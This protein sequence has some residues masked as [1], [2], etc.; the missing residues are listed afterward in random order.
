MTETTTP[1]AKTPTLCACGTWVAIVTTETD[2]NE[3]PDYNIV[4]ST[5][6]DETTV[7]TFRPGHDA[8]LKSLLI[9][10]GAQSLELTDRG[11]LFTDALGVA[12]RYGFLAQVEAG[13]KRAGYKAD[14]KAQ[15]EVG[16][17]A[18]REARATELGNRAQAKAAKA[19]AN[20]TRREVAT[21]PAAQDAA[22]VKIK[23]GRWEYDAEIDAA[24]NASY[25]DSHGE[26]Q[27]REAGSFRIL[28]P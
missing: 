23:V 8:K 5:N 2:E 15:R 12:R 24:G 27:T 17:A 20:R 16:K 28:Q 22:S 4:Y 14:A 26:P 18:R 10:A 13:I 1:A 9:Q 19:A 11:G 21:T 3:Q 25:T 6:C 7:K